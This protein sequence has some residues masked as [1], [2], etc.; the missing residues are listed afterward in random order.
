MNADGF[1]SLHG[2]MLVRKGAAAPSAPS[3]LSMPEKNDTP[4]SGQTGYAAD[5][6]D[7]GDAP[8]RTRLHLASCTETVRAS[9]G[10]NSSARLTAEDMRALRFAAAM[11]DRSEDSLIS[12]AVQ[13]YL[14]SLASGPL[15]HCPCFKSRLSRKTP[16]TT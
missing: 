8:P 3:S 7:S 5:R 13:S 4:T 11:L 2:G 14:E 6:R 12:E 1:A 9:S 15:R 10:G 16:P